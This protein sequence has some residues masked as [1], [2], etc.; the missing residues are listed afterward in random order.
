MMLEKLYPGVYRLRLG[1]PELHTPCSLRESHPQEEALLTQ[2]EQD[3]IFREEEISLEAGS[4]GISVRLP[5]DPEERIY[6]FGLQLKSME[7]GGKKRII[8]TNAD[9]RS[10][11]GESHAP[12]PYY[13]STKGYAVLA[14]SCRDVYFY[15][16]SSRPKSGVKKKGHGMAGTT[17]ELYDSSR[18]AGQMVVEVPAAHG[19][20]LY[21]FVGDDMK[22]AVCRY[23]LFSG[24]GVLPPMWGLGFLYRGWGGQNQQQALSLAK[25]LRRDRIPCD[26]FGFEPGWHTHAYSCT[27]EWD[28]G[29]FPDHQAMLDEMKA[30]HFRVNLWEQAFVYHE[31]S[32]YDRMEPFAGDYLVWEGL[33]PD[34]TLPEAREEFAQKQRERIAEGIDAFKLDECDGSDY[35]GGWSFPACSKFPSG[36]DGEQMHNQLGTHFQ[37][38]VASAFDRRTYGQARAS[39]ALAASLP[40]VLYSDLYDH[41][42][43]VRG[44]ATAGFSG[45]L[46]SPEVRQTETAEEFVRRLQAVCLSPLA[47]INA[48][49]IPNPMWQQFDYEK[50]LAGELLEPAEREQLTALTRKIVEFR[51][52]LIPYLY[53]AFYRYHTEGVPPFRALAMDY[54]EDAEAR[55][56]WDEILI[57]EDLLAAPV[58]Y[59]R[60]NRREIYLPKGEWMDFATGEAFTGPCKLVREPELDEIPLFV[61]AGALLPLAEP[62]EYVDDTPFRIYLV[63]YGWGKSRCF[64]IEDD[65]ESFAYKNGAYNRIDLWA[66]GTEYQVSRSGGYTGRRYEICGYER[67]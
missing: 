54:P 35:T 9:P 19:L 67:K 21:I 13:V 41:S 50:N 51:M 65:G 29:R 57:G 18:D 2:S 7:Q 52:S 30:M 56:I 47:T 22:N 34:F 46:W 53:T 49:M 23:N 8:R 16:G 31:T 37:H 4:R 45:L 28:N 25:E 14:D 61:R 59:G 63:Q 11:T 48:W 1:T 39:H 3:C 15:C 60:G 43:F 24:G 55:D 40:F 27:Y 33:V 36:M 38:T 6:G 42:D 44:L 17:A 26:C 62:R 20:D 10:D 64:L 58:V 12:V 5:L 66:N 32:L